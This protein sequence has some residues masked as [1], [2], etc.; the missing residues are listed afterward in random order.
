MI[1][2]LRI[3]LIVKFKGIIRT[4]VESSC[5]QGTRKHKQS[6]STQRKIAF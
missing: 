6:T 4:M 5:N 3:V 1:M 2:F